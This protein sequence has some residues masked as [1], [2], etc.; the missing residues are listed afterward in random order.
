MAI[1]SN[2][3]PHGKKTTEMHLLMPSVNA[4]SWSQF[5]LSQSQFALSQSGGLSLHTFSNMF[6]YFMRQVVIQ[7]GNCLVNSFL[8]F[9]V[10]MNSKCLHSDLHKYVRK[11][12]P[13]YN[14][15][16]CFFP[17]SLPYIKHLLLHVKAHTRRPRD[18]AIVYMLSYCMA[19]INWLSLGLK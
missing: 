5:A 3:S 13:F 17:L 14:L 1:C 6:S 8:Q 12:V 9:Q 19:R 10:I 16:L 2:L 7:F 4:L 15:P 18:S 11:F